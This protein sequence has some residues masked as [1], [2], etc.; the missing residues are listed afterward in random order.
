MQGNH[1]NC[2]IF[3][4]MF[5]YLDCTN[6]GGSQPLFDQT[7][8]TKNRVRKTRIALAVTRGKLELYLIGTYF[9]V[10]FLLSRT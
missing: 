5:R 8:V 2:G 1:Y 6:T 7:F 4:C 10:I 9:V 3:T